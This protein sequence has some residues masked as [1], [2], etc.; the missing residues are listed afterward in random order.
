[1]VKRIT[2]LLVLVGFC[3]SAF[4]AA[5]ADLA[6][7]Y[8]L[9]RSSGTSLNCQWV[10]KD[11]DRVVMKPDDVGTFID[12]ASVIGYITVK[13][14]A[15]YERIFEIDAKSE[16][17]AN[18]KSFRKTASSS[19]ISRYKNDLFMEIEKKV[20]KLSDELDSAAASTDLVK[21]DSSIAYDKYRR[22]TRA[23]RNELE[24]YRKNRETV[25]TAT[26]A[27]E[28][29]SKVNSALQKSLSG[30]L[31]ALQTPGT[32]MD[33]F[34]VFKDKDGTVDLRQ[35]NGIPD[36]FVEKCKKAK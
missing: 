18:L 20:I 34:K 16:R 9:I 35:L 14:K 24:G 26:P 28:Q 22:E 30:I 13:S 5:P 15:G 12:Q 17:F 33:D 23:V 19:E 25:C 32:C 21:Y 2:M 8:C 4:A 29:V 6:E 36:R 3:Q 11:D 10:N 7:L 27:F 1:M 31:Y